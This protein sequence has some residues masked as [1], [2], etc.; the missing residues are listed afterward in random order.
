MIS[1]F[2]VEARFSDIS[3]EVSTPATIY[4]EYIEAG[5]L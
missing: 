1:R 2:A 5:L 4:T 3:A